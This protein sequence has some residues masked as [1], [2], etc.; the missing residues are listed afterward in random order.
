MRAI[1]RM[2]CDVEP[3]GFI[4]TVVEDLPFLPVAGML[5]AP[6]ALADLVAVDAVMWSAT[7][8]AVIE[9]WLKNQDDRGWAY[10]KKQGFKKGANPK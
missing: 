9:V 6:T 5:I 10:W 2:E 3:T 8:P 1:F 7:A 4:E